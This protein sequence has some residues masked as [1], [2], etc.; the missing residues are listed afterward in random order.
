MIIGKNGILT[1]AQA[2]QA[3]QDAQKAAQEAKEAAH[4]RK[5]S[6]PAL[7]NE[8]RQ[9]VHTTGKTNHL[10]FSLG[11]ILLSVLGA[12]LDNNNDPYR[13]NKPGGRPAKKTRIRKKT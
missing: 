12:K 9:V 1:E 10:C 11:L 2:I 5:L 13:L 3:Q 7:V 8:I 4:L 6:K